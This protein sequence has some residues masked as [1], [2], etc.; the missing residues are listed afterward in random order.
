ME[1]GDKILEAAKKAQ[2]RDGGPAF[3]VVGMDQRGNQTFM[4]V[5]NGGMTMRQYFAGQAMA[6]MSIQWVDGLAY[7]RYAKTCYEIADAMIEVEGK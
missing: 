2:K 6:S 3:P 1:T 7:E 5:F 4:G